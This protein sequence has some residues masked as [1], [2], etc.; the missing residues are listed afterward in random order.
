MPT[1]IKPIEPAVAAK[2]RPVES[3]IKVYDS[4]DALRSGGEARPLEYPHLYQI[5]A[6]EWRIS[7]AV[8]HNRLAIL[9]LEVLTPEGTVRKDPDSEKMTR[10]MKIKLL[11]WPEGSPSRDLPP[12]ELGKKLKIKLLD[13]VDEE[14][15]AR[16]ERRPGM[17]IKFSNSTR[18]GPAKR[19]I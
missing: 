5:Q 7:Y 19:R 8:E 12:E 2:I 1:K 6:G 14:T 18:S 3:A 15:A 4:P 17:K 16:P 13:L 10:K 9:V 11:D